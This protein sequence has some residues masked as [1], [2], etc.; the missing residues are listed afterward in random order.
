MSK[1]LHDNY[2]DNAKAVAIP[3]V[4]SE[5]SW[6]KNQGMFGKGLNVSLQILL[7]SNDRR[8]ISISG[9]HQRKITVVISSFKSKTN[10]FNIFIPYTINTNIPNSSIFPL[11][12]IFLTIPHSIK[13]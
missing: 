12:I 4:F 7:V 3:R 13:Y 9:G 1:F 8:C 2:N 6:A 11:L 10:S 5:N